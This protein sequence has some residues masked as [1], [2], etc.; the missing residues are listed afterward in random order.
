MISVSVSPCGGVATTP[1]PVRAAVILPCPHCGEELITI[2]RR[3]S[4]TETHGLEC[5]PYEHWTESWEECAAC[6]HTIEA[7]DFPRCEQCGEDT[8]VKDLRLATDGK[9]LLAACTVC[10]DE[11]FPDRA[12]PAARRA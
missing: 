12:A 11:L 6:G 8:P 2:E 1:P 10:K 7:D 9:R 5:G 3:E 4:H